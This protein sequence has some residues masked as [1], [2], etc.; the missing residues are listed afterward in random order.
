MLSFFRKDTEGTATE[1]LVYGAYVQTEN[2]TRRC[3]GAVAITDRTLALHRLSICGRRGA[4]VALEAG[5]N[6]CI[7]PQAV[8]ARDAD[9]VQVTGGALRPS[10]RNLMK[11]VHTL[12]ACG[13]ARLLAVIASPATA[14][15]QQVLRRLVPAHCWSVAQHGAAAAGHAELLRAAAIASFFSS[16]PGMAQSS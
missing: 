1:A 12:H 9:V 8:A 3:P 11:K 5:G 14:S 10:A 16:L 7:L 6:V 15:T 2:A 13:V 4:S